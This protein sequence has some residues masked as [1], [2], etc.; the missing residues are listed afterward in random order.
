M[1]NGRGHRPNC[2]RCP[3]SGMLYATGGCSASGRLTVHVAAA[4]AALVAAFTGNN[5]PIRLRLRTGA[6]VTPDRNHPGT[7]FRTRRLNVSASLRFI[8]ISPK[9]SQCF[10]AK[11]KPWWIPDS[12]SLLCCGTSPAP[13]RPGE[14]GMRG[15]APS[16][17]LGRK[18][19]GSAR[20]TWTRSPVVMDVQDSL[21]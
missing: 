21:R 10:E 14:L 20:L 13:Y 7:A 19:M 1:A 18:S 17:S 3:A 15:P 16:V 6:R 2:H 8:H 4:R 11:S 12:C 5:A 9:E